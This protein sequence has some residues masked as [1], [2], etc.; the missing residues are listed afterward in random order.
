MPRPMT[1]DEAVNALKLLGAGHAPQPRGERRGGPARPASASEQAAVFTDGRYRL[2]PVRSTLTLVIIISILVGV[3]IA[4][5]DSTP[6]DRGPQSPDA[7]DRLT[8]DFVSR[9]PEWPS[10]A[11]IAL[12]ETY[13]KRAATGDPV[14]QY[15]LGR[16]LLDG[17]NGRVDIA[18]AMIW[19]EKAAIQGNAEA[20]FDLASI[21]A[22]GQGVPR[23]DQQAVRWFHRAAD[24]GLTMAQFNLAVLYEQGRGVPADPATALNWYQVAAASGDIEA[25]AR[26]DR[27]N[28]M[29]KASR[30][31]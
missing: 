24:S 10:R 17:H 13:V 5:A 6:Q 7:H 25:A 22:G 3:V 2:L 14:A 26:A 16:L 27:L 9:P 12:P 19:L 20:A 1:P 23:N 29:M 31:R 28:A 11:P 21:H 4:V 30:A 15:A 8:L 18:T